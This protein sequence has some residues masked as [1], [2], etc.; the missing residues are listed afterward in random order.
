QHF[1]GAYIDRDQAAGLRV[2]LLDRALQRAVRK[3]LDLAVD[4]E[5][6][7]LSILRG[8]NRLHVLDHAA[9]AILDHAPAAG[10]AAE[11]VLVREL[12]AFLSAVVDAGEADK[13][14]GDFAGGIVAAVF[15]TL[16]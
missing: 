3:A 8:A 16:V 1:A 13:V 10:L 4:R 9:E 11:C 14:R 5:D 2:R 7:I 15:G 12:D 6:Q